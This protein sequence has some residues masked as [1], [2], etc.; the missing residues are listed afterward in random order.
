MES[1]IKDPHTD[2]HQVAADM[3]TENTGV[4][5]SRKAAKTIAF[6]ILYGSGLG[7]LAQSLGTRVDEAKSLRNNYLN[8]F[9]GIKEIQYD[10]KMRARD[11]KD[12]RTAG[13]RKFK[14]EP[15]KYSEKYGRMM[16]FDYKMLNYLIQGSSADQTKDAI[17]RFYNMKTKGRLLLTVHD[18][19]VVS[20]PEGEWEVVMNALKEAMNNAGL[21]VPMVSDGEVGTNWADMAEC[22]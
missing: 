7:S 2:F 12:V 4:E 21:D 9:S 16:S 10:L 8:M 17:I 5:I 13:G 3:I 11:N 18:E 20:A 14:C 22:T 19:I 6:S 1:Y 15:A